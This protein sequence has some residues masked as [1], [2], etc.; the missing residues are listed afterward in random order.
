ML[1]AALAFVLMSADFTNNARI[2]QWAAGGRPSCPGSNRSPELHWTN[3]PPGTR[4]LAL[5]VFDPDA[6]HGFYH[7][8][9]YDLAPTTRE[10]PTGAHVLGYNGPCPPPGPP[11]HYVFTLY[12]LDAATLTQGL[13]GPSLLARMR[14]HILATAQ[15]VGMYGV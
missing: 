8:V 2:P 4:S 10:L 6:P 5:I 12:A 15:L 9:L 14:G 13:D 11:H 7:W 3:P 1:A